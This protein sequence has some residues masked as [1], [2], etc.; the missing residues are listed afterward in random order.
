MI[1]V[2]S[3]EL[4]LKTDGDVLTVSAKKEGRG[5]C[6]EFEQKFTIPDGVNIDKLSSSLSKDGVLTISAPRD[7]RFQEIPAIG[8]DNSSALTQPNMVY[9]DERLTIEIDVQAYK[10]ED[11]DVK[12]DGEELCVTASQDVKDAVSGQSR[13]RVFEQKFSLPSGV[14]PEQVQSSLTRDGK[15]VITAPRT[16]NKQHHN[17]VSQHQDHSPGQGRQDHH[18]GMHLED[19]YA[20]IPL[21]RELTIRPFPFNN[22]RN[23]HLVP[24]SDS[25]PIN[26][27]FS[28][29]MS[30]VEC[31]EENYKILVNVQNFNPEDLVIRTVDDCVI[32]EANHEE[33]TGDGRSFSS[34]SFSQSFNLPKDI[35]PESV[36]S[37]LSKD[38]VLTISAP[39]KLH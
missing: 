18:Q 7:Q 22:T 34:K 20:S 27:H 23:Q 28:N 3:Q 39:F 33:K 6:K 38:G 24:T 5:S 19:D 10:P 26:Y 9:D 8:A 37:A 1:N 31:D 14:K 2:Y 16:D 13:Q 32:V 30:K 4:F 36:T 29:G 17:A 12:I 21:E 11:L 35:N 15:L 25:A